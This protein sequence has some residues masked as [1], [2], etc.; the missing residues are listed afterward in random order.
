MPFL[1]LFLLPFLLASCAGPKAEPAG[2]ARRPGKSLHQ[3]LEEASCPNQNDFRGVGIGASESEALAQARS[4]M[5]LKHFSSKLKSD[6]QITAQNVNETASST[7]TINIGQEAA[8]MN[9]QDAK[10][11]YLARQ[12]NEIGILACMSRSDAEKAYRQMQSQFLDSIEFTALF[13]MKTTH[14]KQKNEARR[15]VDS[16]WARALASQG[17][18][19]SWGTGGDIGKAKDFRDAME[20]DYKDYCQTAKLH[21]NSEHETTYT[22]IAFANLSRKLRIEKSPCDG[23]GI[24]LVYKNP[25]GKCEHAGIFS[26][27][28]QPSLLLASCDGTEYRLLSVSNVVGFHQKEDVALERLQS[29][30]R[31]EAFWNEWEREIKQWSPQCE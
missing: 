31:D 26:C 18:L 19:E 15:K 17:L 16:L 10:L 22:E 5:A 30:L 4:D 23:R 29:K 3:V 20:D 28:H 12:N 13:G 14:P 7:A 1:V 9:P 21:W 6:V 27:S 25:D 11:F 2:E 24:S 8:L